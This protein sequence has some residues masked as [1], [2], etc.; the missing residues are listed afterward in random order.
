MIKL[1][2]KSLLEFYEDYVIAYNGVVYY[3][4]FC[5]SD[6]FPDRKEMGV[7]I[8]QTNTGEEILCSYWEATVV[9]SLI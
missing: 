2:D 3:C 5:P 6:D 4:Q 7:F 8:I 1:E 9:W